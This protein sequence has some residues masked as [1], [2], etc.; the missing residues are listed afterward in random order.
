MTALA[1]RRLAPDERSAATCRDRRRII[2]LEP[3]NYRA[4]YS[5]A[6]WT[7]QEYTRDPSLPRAEAAEQSVRHARYG[8]TAINIMC[9]GTWRAFGSDSAATVKSSLIV[10]FIPGTEERIPEDSDALRVRLAATW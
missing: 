9:N 3:A 7:L 10:A 4:Q 8:R 6:I 1:L 5:L 2:E